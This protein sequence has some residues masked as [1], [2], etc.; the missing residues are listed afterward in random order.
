MK[1][2]LITHLRSGKADCDE[3]LDKYANM[4]VESMQRLAKYGMKE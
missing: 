3:L 2:L 1:P 4:G